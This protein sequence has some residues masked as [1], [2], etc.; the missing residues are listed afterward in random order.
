LRSE[1]MLD[2]YVTA[3]WVTG[4]MVVMLGFWS[5]LKTRETFERDLDYLEE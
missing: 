1:T 2:N 4:V 3:A 5:V